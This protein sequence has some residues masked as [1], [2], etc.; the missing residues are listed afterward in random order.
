MLSYSWFIWLNDAL[1]FFTGFS[2][3]SLE[4][5]DGLV[6]SSIRVET[7]TLESGLNSYKRCPTETLGGDIRTI[8]SRFES[9]PLPSRILVKYCK[10]FS[11]CCSFSARFLAAISCNFF[12]CSLRFSVIRESSSSV[13]SSWTGTTKGN[14]IMHSDARRASGELRERT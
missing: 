13:F 4:F 14:W 11:F 10:S 5:L 1:L 7:F 2:N 9:P 6:K 12:P 8:H 3:L